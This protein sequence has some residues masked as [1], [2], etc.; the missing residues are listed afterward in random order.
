M[1]L[2][3]DVDY[4]ATQAQAA[5]VVLDNWT[6]P[7]AFKEYKLTIPKIHEYI[8]GQ[9]YKREL[10]CLLALLKTIE[11]PIT[12]ILVDGYVWLNND[13]KPGLGAY[14]HKALD[15]KIPIIG[16]AKNAFKQENKYAVPIYRGESTK[17]LYITSEGISVEEA[18]TYIQHMAGDYRIPTLLKKV[19]NLCREWT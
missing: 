11:E 5:A 19:D 14:L 16:V 7:E 12:Y 2:A 10:P 3:T 9:F 1:I 8:S 17:P 4:Q 13:Q 18:Q 15:P 6:D